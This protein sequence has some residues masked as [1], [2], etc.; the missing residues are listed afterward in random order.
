MTGDG[1]RIGI[2]LG[3]TKIE[4]VALDRDGVERYRLR[5]PTPAGDYHATMMRV[6]SLAHAC[7]REL[8]IV[9]PVGV[10]TPGAESLATG[11]MKNAN[12]TVL[13]GRPLRKDLELAIGR[14]IRLENDANC[15]ALSEATDGAA[16]DAA[17]VFGVILGTGVGGGIVIDRKPLLG[18][19]AIAGEW[20]HTPLPWP[21]ADE[22]PGP[23]CYCGRSGC[24]ETW[25]SGPGFAR[26]FERVTGRASDSKAIVAAAATGDVR[27]LAAIERYVDRLAR[28]LAIVCN[29]LDP[30][31]IVLGGGMSNVEEIARELPAALGRRVFTDA[32]RTRVARATFGDASGVRGAARLW[33]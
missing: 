16:A 18:A 11:L 29:V 17:I 20:G 8:G 31:A 4:A 6:A 28:G 14:E 13:N 10:G 12:S 27:A 2:D 26:E 3:G 7:E 24:M 1:I 33:D 23:P 5:V 9:A 32:F 21:S 22:L 19:N 15:F 25:I 30:D